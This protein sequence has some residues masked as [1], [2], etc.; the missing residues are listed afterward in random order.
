MAWLSY[1]HRS[2]SFAGSYRRYRPGCHCTRT[3]VVRSIGIF[4]AAASLS[5]H[6]GCWPGHCPGGLRGCFRARITAWGGVAAARSDKAVSRCALVTGDH[7][8]DCGFAGLA[9]DS[10]SPASRSM[11]LARFSHA[12]VRVLGLDDFAM[13]HGDKYGTIFVNVETGKPLDLLPDREASAVLPWLASHQEIEVV[14]RDRARA[15]ADAVKQALPHAVQVADCYH[16]IQICE[17]IFK[18]SWIANGRV[19]R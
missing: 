6:P 9:G 13:R 15:Y 16:L 5:D 4:C 17:N 18:S 19:C 11:S 2:F 8:L 7:R 1:R 3:P 14:S 12:S 10:T